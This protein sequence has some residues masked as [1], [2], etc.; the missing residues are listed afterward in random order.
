M[1][2]CAGDDESG[3]G[4]DG[5]SQEQ[6]QEQPN[7]KIE[8]MSAFSQPEER[9]AEMEA[10]GCG[11][12]FTEWAKETIGFFTNINDGNWEYVTADAEPTS[13]GA[14][15]KQACQ[16]TVQDAQVTGL[17]GGDLNNF[18]ITAYGLT[19]DS[20]PMRTQPAMQLYEQAREAASGASGKNGSPLTD[21]ESFT[22]LSPLTEAAHTYASAEGLPLEGNLMVDS[23]GREISGSVHDGDKA[24]AFVS[25]VKDRPDL[26]EETTQGTRGAWV[27]VEADDPQTP[28]GEDEETSAE[29]LAYAFTLAMNNQVNISKRGEDFDLS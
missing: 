12:Q 22:Q 24:L 28:A 29:Q 11:A 21:M 4:V 7:P 13:I 9:L 20:N 23:S 15:G 14:D 18:T 1:V 5:Q 19:S 8:R 26:G 16:V 17:E 10:E 27:A 2:S 3:E 25:E 6:A